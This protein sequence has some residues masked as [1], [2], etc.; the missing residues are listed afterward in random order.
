MGDKTLL[1]RESRMAT[2]T[3]DFPELLGKKR[4]LKNLAKFTGKYL[5]WSLFLHKVARLSPE[6]QL[7]RDSNTGVFLHIFRN[8]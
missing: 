7:K 8:F 4:V 5:C 6:T 2:F 1:S 3:S